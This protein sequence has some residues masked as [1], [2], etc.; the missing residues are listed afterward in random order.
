MP[1]WAQLVELFQPIGIAGIVCVVIGFIAYKE[2]QRA[3]AER[4]IARRLNEEMR[5]QLIQ[6]NKDSNKVASEATAAIQAASAHIRMQTEQYREA[7]KENITALVQ[8]NHS[9]EQTNARIDRW[10][11]KNGTGAI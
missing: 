10:I 11:I 7:S 9:I 5:E 2:R 4:D 3:D 1:A 8:I 6:L